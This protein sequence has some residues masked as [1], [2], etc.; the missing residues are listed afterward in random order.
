MTVYHVPG[1]KTGLEIKD[2][3]G[4]IEDNITEFKGVTLSPNYPWKVG[5]DYEHKEKQKKFFVHLVCFAN[6]ADWS[7]CSLL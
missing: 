1:Y 6:C 4:T 2:R 7:G 3:E 5:F